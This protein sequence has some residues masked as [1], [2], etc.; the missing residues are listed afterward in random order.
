MKLMDFVEKLQ[1][2]VNI[3]EFG[4][5]DVFEV[6]IKEGKLVVELPFEGVFE[7]ARHGLG[8]CIGIVENDHLVL[9]ARWWI[10]GIGDVLFRT[11]LYP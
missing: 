9:E 10:G 3:C 6:T 8:T 4:D 2:L 7:A 1:G 5:L 11:S